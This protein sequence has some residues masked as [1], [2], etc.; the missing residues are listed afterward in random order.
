M[1]ILATIK[2][3]SELGLSPFNLILLAILYAL[4]VQTGLFPRFWKS[5]DNKTP[6]LQDIHEIMIHLKNHYNDATTENLEL[7]GDN[8]KE[9]IRGINKISSHQDA[10]KTTVDDV[11]R[12]Q[13][14]WNR[15]GVK[16]NKTT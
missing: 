2:F 6:T 15:Y 8:Q 10:I 16:V 14:E 9:M 1:D 11:K 7:I 4:G 13:D 12:T 3:L 5:E